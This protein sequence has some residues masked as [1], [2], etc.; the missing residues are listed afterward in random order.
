MVKQSTTASLILL[1]VF[2]YSVSGGSMP[3]N[4]YVT[5]FFDIKRGES[6]SP[7]P[8]EYYYHYFE[9]LLEIDI[10]LIIF[11]DSMLKKFVWERRQKHN[12]H[13]I[14]TTMEDIRAKWFYGRSE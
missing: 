12:T 13:F 10:N 1:T 2:T 14:E 9:M 6:L 11:R 5:S 7:R 3:I 8:V 4:T